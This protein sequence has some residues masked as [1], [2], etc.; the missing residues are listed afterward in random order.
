MAT[1]IRMPEVAAG[2]TEIVL[3]KWQVGVG[4][5]VK[6]GDI[7]AE[8]ETEKAI[9]DYAAEIDGVV[10]KIL[11][12]DG[13]SV[14]VGSPILILLSPG[15]DGSAGDALLG[16]SAATSAPIAAPLGVPASPVVFEAPVPA[17]AVA[18]PTPVVSQQDDLRKLVSPIVRKIARERGVEISQLVGTGPQGRVVRRDLE[19]A[20]ASGETATAAAATSVSYSSSSELAKQDYS[21]SYVTVPHT[22]MRQAIARRLTESK[23]TVPHFYLTADCKVDALLE[24]RKSINETSSIKISVNDIV[25]K[26]VGSALMDVPESN[27]VWNAEAMYKYESADIS[28]A[29]TTEG[30]LFTPVIRGVEKRSLSNLSLEISELASRARA[31][32]LRQED[33]EGGSFAVSNL[34]MFGTQEF[35]AILNPPQSGI[36]AVGAASPRAIVEDGQV[37]VANIM[38]V[39]LS[40]DHR[41]VDGALAA[42]WLSAFVKRIENPLSMLI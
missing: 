19:K 35:S 9:V 25:V 15:E 3:S 4:S 39:T 31:G 22:K 40:A 5:S 24:L 2:A 30:G 16:G 11:V 17:P 36:L 27:V 8:M 7:L 32:K 1:L 37:V 38:T 42:Q 41:A 18:A 29:V 34:G 14:E 33:L 23:T 13:S 6:M 26:A 21:S 12:A 10:H 20:L 28:I